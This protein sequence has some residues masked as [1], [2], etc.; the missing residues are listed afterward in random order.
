MQN[1]WLKRSPMLA[2]L[3]SGCADPG[4]SPEILDRALETPDAPL[5]VDVRSKFEYRRGHISGAVHVPFWNVAG[6]PDAVIEAC[7]RRPVVVTC[8]HGPRAAFAAAGLRRLGCENVRMLTGHMARW[9]AQ[10]RPM[11]VPE[12]RP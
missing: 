10:E 3:L 12:R 8:E 5:V 6:A 9:R 7:R 2:V 1:K 11:I 4:I